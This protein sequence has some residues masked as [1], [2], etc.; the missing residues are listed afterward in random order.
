MFIPKFVVA[1]GSLRFFKRIPSSLMDEWMTDGSRN[2][3]IERTNYLTGQ[4]S[5]NH[6][7]QCFY[8][9][10]MAVNSKLVGILS[11]INH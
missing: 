11:S 6:S 1:F 9:C 4:M 7:K 2:T 8:I 10:G 5:E 3:L